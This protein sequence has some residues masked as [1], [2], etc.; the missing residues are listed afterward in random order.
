MTQ[1]ASIDPPSADS[2]ASA[3]SGARRVALE[4]IVEI[5]LSATATRRGIDRDTLDL[6]A[7]DVGQL[8]SLVGLHDVVEQGLNAY[9]AENSTPPD[10]ALI[11]RDAR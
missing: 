6:L 5:A 8:L 9:I 3:A 2:T 11:W 7:G 1:D 10:P 4:E